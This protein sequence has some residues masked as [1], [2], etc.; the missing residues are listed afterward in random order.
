MHSQ[1]K[2]SL[3]SADILSHIILL[4]PVIL[5]VFLLIQKVFRRSEEKEPFNAAKFEQTVTKAP[6]RK[7]MPRR[8][9]LICGPV[10]SGKTGIFY[11]LVTGENRDTVTS[12]EINDSLGPISVKIPSEVNNGEARTT[13][14]SVIDVPGHLHFREKVQEILDETRAILLIF[15]AKEK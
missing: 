13:L 14:L 9:L 11:H 8:H 12:Q 10:H 2:L 15:D 1:L 6:K 4:S 5:I 3:P 7:R